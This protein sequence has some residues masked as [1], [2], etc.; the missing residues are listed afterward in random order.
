MKALVVPT[1]IPGL[2]DVHVEDGRDL[3]DM[4]IGQLQFLKQSGV[5]LLMPRF[6]K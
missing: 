1:E 6:M 3:T 5:D 2:Y 4:T